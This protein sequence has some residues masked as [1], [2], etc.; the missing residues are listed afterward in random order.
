MQNLSVNNSLDDGTKELTLHYEHFFHHINKLLGTLLSFPNKLRAL[1]ILC[2]LVALL[3]AEYAARRQH[4]G[5]LR[6]A[7][8]SLPLYDLL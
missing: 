2:A 4:R 7:D 6:A 5:G 3:L 8:D 1:L